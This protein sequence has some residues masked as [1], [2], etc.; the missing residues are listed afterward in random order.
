MHFGFRI[1]QILVGA[2]AALLFKPHFTSLVSSKLKISGLGFLLKHDLTHLSVLDFLKKP[3]NRHLMEAETNVNKP[4]LFYEVPSLNPRPH[5]D[6]DDLYKSLYSSSINDSEK[7]WGQLGIQSLLWFTKFTKVLSGS[8]ENGTSRWFSDG[9]INASYN[10]L[11][12]HDPNKIALIWESDTQGT[13]RYVTFGELLRETCKLSNF[14]TKTFHVKKGDAVTIYLPMTPEVV[15]AMLACAR[16]GAIHN[17]VFAGFSANSLKERILNSESR[18]LITADCAFRGGKRVP[19][20][21]I[22][23]EASESLDLDIL[24]LKRDSE[25]SF[26]VK[27]GTWWHDEV[28]KQSPE[29][30]PE[31][32]NGDSPLFMLYTSGSTGKPKG[33]VH[34]T[35][36][37]LLYAMITARYVFDLQEGDIFGCLADVGWITGH[38]YVVYGPLANGVTTVLFEGTPIYPNPTRYWELVQRLRITQLYIAPTV[39]RSLKKLGDQYVN[40]YDLSSLRVLGTVGEPINVD[41]WEWYHKVVGKGRCAVADTYWQTE[42]G[43]HLITP[44]PGAT[45]TKAGSAAY[46]FFG[47]APKIL[48]QFTGEDI[49]DFKKSGVIVISQ[50]WPGLAMYQPFY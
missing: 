17:V 38:S 28:T 30:E 23:T 24:W 14:L 5:I 3:I 13:T 15:I 26:F 19:L 21:E 29:Y 1:D 11:D 39:I 36:G 25:N 42:T 34:S 47:I 33:L 45:K 49:T 43:G 10:C 6:S 32:M 4:P 44:L 12:R 27:R 48:D 20:G 8:F 46:P 41:A 18:V 35:A 37:Y 31:H 40:N 16:I 50:S 9:S 2:F 22:A 7:F